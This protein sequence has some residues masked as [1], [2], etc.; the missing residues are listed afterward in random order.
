MRFRQ[1]SIPAWGPF[2]GLQLDFGSRTPDFHV[3]HGPNE[4]GKS[5]LLRGIT[6][7]L[8]GIPMQAADNFLH[9]YK[10]LRLAAEIQSRSGETLS[11]QRRKGN[12]RTLLGPDDSELSNH[13]LEPFLGSVDRSSK[14][15]SV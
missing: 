12:Q 14:P 6:Q 10:D 7:L 4:A 5:S 1:L 2:T 15:C 9:A 11:F 13:A 8:Y 3:I